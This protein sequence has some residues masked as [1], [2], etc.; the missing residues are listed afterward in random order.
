MQLVASLRCK[1]RASSGVET[2]AARDRAT[3]LEGDTMYMLRQ[4]IIQ[5]DRLMQRWRMNSTTAAA[6]ERGDWTWEVAVY[7]ARLTLTSK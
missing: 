1:F 3:L 4:S 2:P 7:R 6:N 5:R